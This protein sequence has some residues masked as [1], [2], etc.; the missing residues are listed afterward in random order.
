MRLRGTCR[1]CGSTRSTTSAASS[2]T[3]SGASASTAT[4]VPRL[5]QPSDLSYGPVTTA[6]HA[7]H[8]HSGVTARTQGSASGTPRTS[9]YPSDSSHSRSPVSVRVAVTELRLLLVGLVH[10]LLDQLIDVDSGWGNH[11]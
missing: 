7:P 4:P 8:R 1:R 11:P 3:A 9:S 6:R 5:K 10:D 2:T